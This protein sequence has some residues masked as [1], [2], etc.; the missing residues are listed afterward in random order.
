MDK[1]KKSDSSQP[2]I[3]K[4]ETLIHIPQDETESNGEKW[5]LLGTRVPQ[6]EIVYFCQMK[7]VYIVII[8]SIINLSL[9]NGSKELWISFLSSCIWYALPSPNLK[10]Q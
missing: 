5:H 3:L 1:A 10:K 8:I 2:N 6:T 9:E 7:V 4:R